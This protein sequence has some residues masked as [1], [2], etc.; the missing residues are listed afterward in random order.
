MPPCI[1]AQ[2]V[3]ARSAH[4]RRR[5]SEASARRTPLLGAV[6]RGMLARRHQDPRA[7]HG[8]GGRPRRRR[9]R[10]RGRAWRRVL[11]GSRGGGGGG[12]RCTEA[13]LPD[14][15]EA[16]ARQLVRG[17]GRA[18]S[19]ATERDGRRGDADGPRCPR[20]SRLSGRAARCAGPDGEAAR[21]YGP[22]AA[23]RRSRPQRRGGPAPVSRFSKAG[24][25]RRAAA[26]PAATNWSIRRRS[27]ALAA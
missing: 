20:H 17:A 3:F 21:R 25:R 27:R 23:R 26:S 1:S 8:G 11:R 7:T 10:P 19:G 24:S 16:R 18:G 13:N 5:D 4:T 2:T 14:G 22:S 12:E 15:G 9:R 6:V